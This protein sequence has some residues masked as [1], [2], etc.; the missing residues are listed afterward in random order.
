M[1]GRRV[2]ELCFSLT[3]KKAASGGPVLGSGP[4]IRH[5]KLSPASENKC[6]VDMFDLGFANTSY[7]YDRLMK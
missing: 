7:E 4:D 6:H 5:R 1:E 2:L 3:L